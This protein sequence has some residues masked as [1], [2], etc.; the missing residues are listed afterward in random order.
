MTRRSYQL[1]IVTIRFNVIVRDNF[2]GGGSV[3]QE[4]VAFSASTVAG[5]F[6]LIFPNDRETT[7]MEGQEIEVV[8]NVANTTAE[9]ISCEAVDIMLSYNNG[10]SYADTL[11][12]DAPNLG[13]AFVT[14]PFGQTTNRA[15]I[16]IKAANNV[17]FD[18]SDDYFH[19]RRRNS[20]SKRN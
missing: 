8:W 3:V 2:D 13:S 15:R 12:H 18:I 14:I 16:K 9:P 11:L 1:T 10:F 5:P 6:Q 7:L 19:Y 20:S 4:S 17:F